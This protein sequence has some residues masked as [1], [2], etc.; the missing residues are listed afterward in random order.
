VR[1]VGIDLSLTGTGICHP[2]GSTE[3][4]K[5]KRTGMD[6]LAW[7]RDE[8]A[9]R[10]YLPHSTHQV[11]L[12]VIEG[13]SYGSKGRA[14]VNI[15]ELGGVLRLYL[16]EYG[17]PFVE[18]PPSCLKKYATGRGN[19][20]K[21]D[22]LQAAVI[23]SGHTF[24]DN[25]AADAWWLWQMALAH[26]CPESPLLVRMPKTHQDGLAKVAWAA[27]GEEAA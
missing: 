23:R 24:A 7:I 25:N 11:D 6:R 1:I 26:Y 17:P 9:L 27:I 3:T 5:P 10:C 2:D 22:M 13:Y 21:E 4:L 12:I 18:I 15:G 14:V 16:H 20:G 8:I 19:A